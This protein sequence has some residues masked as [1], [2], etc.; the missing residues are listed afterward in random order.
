MTYSMDLRERVVAQLEAGETIAAVARR[1]SVS[2]PTVRNWR[3][4]ARHDALHP[5]VPG[6]RRPHK[7]T[8]ADDQQLRYYAASK[9]PVTA[10]ELA[11]ML[12]VPVTVATVYRRLNRLNLRLNKRSKTRL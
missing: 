12:S 1:F 2:R 3:E 6:P 10:R 8:E 4:R 7:L 5:Q 11:G 9:R